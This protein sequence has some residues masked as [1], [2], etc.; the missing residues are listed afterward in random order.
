[1]AE[2]LQRDLKGDLTFDADGAS[3]NTDAFSAKQNG[4]YVQGIYQFLPRWRTGLRYG[5]LSDGTISGG[6]NAANGIV[7]TGFA[8]ERWSAMVDWSPSEFSR[9]RLQY[10]QDKTQQ[11]LTDHQVY[12]QGIFS[13]GTHGAHKY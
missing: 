7:S 3:P 1:V 5:Q 4:W 6:S 11:G 9:L 13:L 2:W 8:P 10:N 12:L